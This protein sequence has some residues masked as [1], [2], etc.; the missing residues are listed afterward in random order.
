MER[1]VLPNVIEHKIVSRMV[2]VRAQ[3][4][5]ILAYCGEHDA[6]EAEMKRLMPYEAGLAPE[7]QAELRGQRKLITR[8]RV[9]PPAAQWQMPLPKRK[10]GRNERGYCGSG[11]KYKHC[12]GK[13]A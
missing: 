6:A 7:A 11:K 5:V 10:M 13:R 3:Y 8:L 1:N 4:A 2:P 12:H 9:Q